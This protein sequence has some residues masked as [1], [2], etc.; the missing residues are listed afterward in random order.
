MKNHPLD[1]A[2]RRW[3]AG[4][5]L[6]RGLTWLADLGDGL[7]ET[8]PIAEGERCLFSLASAPHGPNAS[9]AV[10]FSIPSLP[11]SIPSL[12][13]PSARPILRKSLPFWLS[14]AVL[15]WAWLGSVKPSPTGHQALCY[16]AELRGNPPLRSLEPG[17]ER[18]EAP[19]LPFIPKFRAV[20]T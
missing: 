19:R 20:G 15:P 10:P 7:G 16:R 4:A 14:H 12:L 17:G 1:G 3:R 9:K 5:F 6:G 8:Y 11:F 18:G 2:V 13:A